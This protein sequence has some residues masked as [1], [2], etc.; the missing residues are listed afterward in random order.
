[1]AI[2]GAGS[3]WDGHEIQQS[4]FQNNHYLIGWDIVDAED[5]YTL[6]STIKVGDIIY[7]KANRPGSLDVRIKGIGFVTEPL[8]LSLL[9][10]KINLAQT[11]INFELPVEWVFQDEYSIS[12]P[13][14]TGKLT[15]IRA[16]TLYEEHLPF[17][18]NN[19]LQS[20]FNLIN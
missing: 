5:L 8:M 3:N 17:V 2:F 10:K 4:L 12:I 18:Q 20:I 7:L 9:K 16:A 19:I 1:M 15:N 11:R 6:I 14:N 13:P